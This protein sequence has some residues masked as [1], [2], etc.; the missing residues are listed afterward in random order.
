MKVTQKQN[1]VKQ[2]YPE[3]PAV[4]VKVNC[5]SRNEDDEQTEYSKS[6]FPSLFTKNC[7]FQTNS[8]N[9]NLQFFT[10]NLKVFFEL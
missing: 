4:K 3:E 8:N 9:S 2:K 1:K 6:R 10:D 7:V 5:T